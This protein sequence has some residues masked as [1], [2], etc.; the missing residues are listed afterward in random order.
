MQMKIDLTV[1][2]NYFRNNCGRER[3]KAEIVK[4]GEKGKSSEEIL[5]LV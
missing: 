3:R 4:E 1:L 5:M 2:S